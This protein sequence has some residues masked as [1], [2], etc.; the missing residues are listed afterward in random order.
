MKKTIK[1]YEKINNYKRH[2][3]L[4]SK[5]FQKK[6]KKCKR[7]FRQRGKMGIFIA[8]ILCIFY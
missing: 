1:K 5:M 3:I 4:R 6:G 2:N 8:P 7:S